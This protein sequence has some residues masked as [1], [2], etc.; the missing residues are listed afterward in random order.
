VM[1]LDSCVSGISLSRSTSLVSLRFQDSSSALLVMSSIKNLVVTQGVTVATVIHQPR[2]FIF[3]L[4]DSLILLGIGG[5]T[6]YHG[7]TSLAYDYF[8]D[9]DYSLPK[10]EALGDWLIDISCGQIHP[11]PEVA[12]TKALEERK[13]TKKAKQRR[14]K[15]KK[16]NVSEELENDG[17]SSGVAILATTGGDEDNGDDENFESPMHSLDVTSGVIVGKGVT[18][19]KVNVAIQDAMVRRK[20]LHDMWENYFDNLSEEEKAIYTAPKETDLPDLPRRKSFLSQLMHQ[21]SRAFRVSN[22]NMYSKLI[23]T[24]VLIVAV[25]VITVLQKTP[26]ESYDRQPNIPFESLVNPTEER[27]L[28]IGS[29]LFRYSLAPQYRY[30][31]EMGS[32]HGWNLLAVCVSCAKLLYSP[33][34]SNAGWTGCSRPY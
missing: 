10:G 14:K 19:G 32:S 22:R 30:V 34:L 33:Q 24:A 23:D 26:I 28:G 17:Q 8:S 16:K 7:P 1:M 12:A 6:I 25:V 11:T 15:K 3:D 31:H 29:E 27:L 9:L 20:W 13:K 4:F 21:L 18:V 2:K 5:R